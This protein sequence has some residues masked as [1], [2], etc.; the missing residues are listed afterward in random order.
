MLKAF[1]N[2]ARAHAEANGRPLL[3]IGEGRDAVHIVLD[4]DFATL[5]AKEIAII[6]PD[7]LVTGHVTLG[8]LDRL[9]NANV[10]IKAADA[11]A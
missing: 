3:R 9:G 2:P 7:G 6:A 1:K 8:H 11:A 4:G 10:A 5:S